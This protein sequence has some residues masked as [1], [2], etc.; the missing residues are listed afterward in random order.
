MFVR[1]APAE[2]FTALADSVTFVA[3]VLDAGS[4]LPNTVC[5][6]AEAQQ[7]AL[8]MWSRSTR[9]RLLTIAMYVHFHP[10]PYQA[11]LDPTPFTQ[12]GAS[13]YAAHCLLQSRTVLVS[14]TDVLTAPFVF[15]VLL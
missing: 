15:H 11:V 6:H 4:A 10:T 14:A 13:Q 9:A 5:P 8:A 2:H 12:T 1:V 3:L 7:Q